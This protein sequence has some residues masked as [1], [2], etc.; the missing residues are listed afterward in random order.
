MQPNPRLVIE[1]FTDG[2]LFF[3]AVQ[4][5]VVAGMHFVERAG[6]KSTFLALLCL[7]NGLWYFYFIF[8]KLWKTSWVLGILIGP[9]KAIFIPVLI[10]FYLKSV[11][12]P[13]NA[14]VINPHLVFPLLFYAVSLFFHFNPDLSWT[15]YPKG[16]PSP[17][18]FISITYFWV[19]FFK[20]RKELNIR[21]KTTLLPKVF[22]RVRFFFYAFYL[23]LLIIPLVDGL[24]SYFGVQS[25][26]FH[27]LVFYYTGEVFYG[28]SYFLSYL[29]SLYAL[30]ELNFIRKLLFPGNALLSKN[31]QARK[32]EI[33][34]LV[35]EEL[36]RNKLF[37]NPGISSE[38]FASDFKLTKKEV[39]EYFEITGRGSFNEFI[40]RLRVE[41]FKVRVREETNEHLDLVGLA[42]D[43]GFQSKS[44]FFRVF[45]EIEGITPN[46]YKK[47]ETS[48]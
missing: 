20:A 48:F 10:Y 43:C 26:S 46:E 38:S 16:R 9:D 3:I 32:S 6:Q 40:N 8:F 13:L 18:L 1:T 34:H 14:H 33:A 5:L 24:I 36:I 17:L 39:L 21:L 11:R 31:I 30:T 28:F 42:K 22:K 45:K 37:Q 25:Q 4:L 27:A 2:I 19:Y 29:L 12:G 7:V 41:E 44:T 15:A 35:D 47:R 23:P